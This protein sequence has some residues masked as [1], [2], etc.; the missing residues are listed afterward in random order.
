M[1]I[2]FRSSLPALVVIVSV[3][4]KLQDKSLLFPLNRVG[5]SFVT[6]SFSV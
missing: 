1:E 5:L 3:R 4:N 2:K 6:D